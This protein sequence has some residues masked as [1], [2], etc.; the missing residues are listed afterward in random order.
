[1]LGW[2]GVSFCL[3]LQVISYSFRGRPHAFVSLVSSV[4]LLVIPISTS[5]FVRTSSSAYHSSVIEF[6]A[7]ARRR[8]QT[9]V[10]GVTGRYLSISG[11]LAVAS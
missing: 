2:D 10:V 6:I 4:P 7:L 8:R 11:R 5:V 3:R 1:M 9:E